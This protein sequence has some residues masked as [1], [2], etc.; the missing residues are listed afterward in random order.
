M[1]A[2]PSFA[3]LATFAA[4]AWMAGCAAEPTTVASATAAG[5]DATKPAA[6]KVEPLTGSRIARPGTDRIVRGISNQGFRDDVQIR[7][8]GNEVGIRGN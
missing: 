2:H 8:L 6:Q 5:G 1:R 4:A 7:S 3:L